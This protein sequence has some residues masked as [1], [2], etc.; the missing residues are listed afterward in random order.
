M[1]LGIAQC[2]EKERKTRFAY[3]AT[4]VITCMSRQIYDG[5]LGIFAPF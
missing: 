1:M 4:F 2:H 3:F 5:V